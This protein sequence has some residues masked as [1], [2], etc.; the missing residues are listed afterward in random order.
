M[1]AIRYIGPEAAVIIDEPYTYLA[2]GA[3]T[4]VPDELAA[5]LL[6]QDQFV[7]ADAP[8]TDPTPAPAPAE[9][10]TD[11]PADAAPADAPTSQEG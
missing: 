11:T 3:A 9:A 7:P 5:G 10:A 1:T 4:D 2:H 6:L 8:A